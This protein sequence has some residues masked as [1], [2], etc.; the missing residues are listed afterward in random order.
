MN[1]TLIPLLISCTLFLLCGVHPILGD[2]G[3]GASGKILIAVYASGSNL[4]TDLDLITG[5]IRQLVTG[6]NS[7]TPDILEVVVAYGGSQKPGWQG[8]KVANSSGLTTDLEDDCL[9][10]LSHTILNY[11]DANM[12]SADALSMFIRIVNDRYQYDRVFLIL[13]GHGEAYTGM[14]TD[15]NHDDDPLTLPE[16]KSALESGGKNVE[17]IGLDSCLMGSI[18]VASAIT[19]FADYLIASEES[20]PAEGWEYQ[21]WISYLAAHPDAP[22][23]QHGEIL[24]NTYLDGQGGGRTLSIMDLDEAGLVTS[25]LDRLAMNIIPLSE[26]PGGYQILSQTIRDTQQFGLAGDGVLYPVTMDISDLAINIKESSP[27]LQY[28]AQDLIAA[29]DTMI[30]RSVHNGRIPKAFGISVLSPVGITAPFYQ[31]YRDDAAVTPSW[32]KFISR[33]LAIFPEQEGS[34]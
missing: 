1:K 18:E 17:L 23:Q 19:G 21:T 26:T 28:Q 20:E 8:M 22:I 29:V 6:A 33:Y 12:G 14:L 24:L 16:F 31:Y 9:G 5:D 25:R 3:T 32:D 30:V 11:P 15:Q 10:N 4:E 7:T 34:R 13:I 27:D 2:D